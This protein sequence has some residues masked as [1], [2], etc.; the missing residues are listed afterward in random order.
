MVCRLTLPCRERTYG[1][2]PRIEECAHL[3]PARISIPSIRSSSCARSWAGVCRLSA[4]QS[5]YADRLDA[6][7]SRITTFSC[8]LCGDAGDVVLEDPAKEGLQHDPRPNPI[9][10][11]L[12]ALRLRTLHALDP[13]GHKAARETLPQRT[14]PYLERVP[15]YPLK[16]MPFKTF[17]ELPA[18]GLALSIYCPR[19]YTT[20]LRE[21][22]GRLAPHRWGC[23]RFT[24]SRTRYNGYVCASRG[25]LHLGPIEP[26]SPDE[27]FV[28][29]ECGGRAA[30]WFA[31]R[32]QFGRPPWTLAPIDSAKERYRCPGGGGRVRTTFHGKLEKQG[33]DAGH[34][35]GLQPQR[36][37]S[38]S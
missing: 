27:P 36:G 34:L 29:M 3:W 9:R 19:C 25:H 4:V 33:G 10:H 12:A 22:D 21:I 31:E 32:V 35:F 23:V 38:F 6:R 5:L 1:Y 2:R 26:M 8:L 17:G 7:D 24:C 37:P 15:R 11:R 28:S 13:S 20:V 14:K 16:P 30:P 18:L